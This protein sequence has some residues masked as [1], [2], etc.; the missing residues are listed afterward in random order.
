MFDDIR[1]KLERA[2][3]LEAEGTILNV[4][5]VRSLLTA[6][7]KMEKTLEFYAKGWCNPAIDKLIAEGSFFPYMI[8]ET[9]QGIDAGDFARKTLNEIRGKK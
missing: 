1:E 2:E 8:D 7:D 5:E 6:C 4:K 9:E 3:R